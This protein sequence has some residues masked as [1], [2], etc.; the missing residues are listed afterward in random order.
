MGFV[1]LAAREAEA[2]LAGDVPVRL[3]A[4]LSSPR[5]ERH[6]TRHRTLVGGLDARLGAGEIEPD[7]R[8]V[9]QRTEVAQSVTHGTQESEA[10]ILVVVRGEIV[11][12]PGLELLVQRSGAP[13]RVVLLPAVATEMHGIQLDRFGLSAGCEALRIERDVP[14]TRRLQRSQHLA[15][16]TDEL[17]HVGPLGPISPSTQPEC[18]RWPPLPRP[19]IVRRHQEAPERVTGLFDRTSRIACQAVAGIG[20]RDGLR[21][22]WRAARR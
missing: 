14:D 2:E 17:D 9:F 22:P 19:D 11:D 7:V 20:E 16:A 6:P 15:G 4:S 1:Q 18:K 12:L 10:H 21:A 13:H 5:V 8:Q 3:A